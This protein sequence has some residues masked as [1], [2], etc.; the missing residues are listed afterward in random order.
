VVRAH[1]SVL[2]RVVTGIAGLLCAGCVAQIREERIFGPP[3]T[4]VGSTTQTVE[5]RHDDGLPGLRQRSGEAG[6][7][8]SGS[9]CREVAV[10]SPLV[11]DVTIRRYFADDAQTR[12]LA[13]AALLGTGIALMEY[14]TNQAACSE[15]TGICHDFATVTT[16]EIVL[17]ALAAIPIGFLGYNAVR[18]QDSVTTDYVTPHWVPGAWAPCPEKQARTDPTRGEP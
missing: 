3:R 5:E 4:I 14:G 10:T 7:V 13:M 15:K 17:L 8:P 6:D 1:R 12:N 11:R 18:V 16:A 9:V 2:F